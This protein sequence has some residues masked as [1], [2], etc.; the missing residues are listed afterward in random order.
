M[1]S[2]L[3]I[4]LLILM[5]IIGKKRGFKIFLSLC[6]NFI[7]LISV[8]YLIALKISPIFITIIGLIF[9]S[10]IILYY[11]NGKNDKTISSLISVIL[12]FLVL[13]LLI[14]FMVVKSRITGFGTESLD[15]INM[16]SENIN[17]DFTKI[18]ISLILIGLIGAT[19]DTSI[20]ISS[21][22][23]EIYL[24]NK[25]ISINELFK[26]GLSIGRD[27]IGTSTNTLLFAF[28]GE[29]M[30]L[31]IWFKTGNYSFSEILNNKTFN[32]EI[33][34]IL[35]SIIGCILVIPITSIITSYRLIKYKKTTKYISCF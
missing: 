30:T 14:Y 11:V 3:L 8:F 15:E 27:I 21:A 5:L 6:F 26:S 35:F 4:I 24:T 20:S 2:I 23:N 9:I 1:N 32:Q 34:K 29:F 10:L 16:F 12:I 7:I 18:T 13:V 19:I 28:L 17:I 33:I 22:L 31:L 25:K